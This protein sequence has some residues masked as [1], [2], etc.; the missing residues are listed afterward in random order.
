M[1][2]GDKVKMTSSGFHFYHN[3]PQRFDSFRIGD[4]LKETHCHN[5]L[6]ETLALLG[7]GEVVDTNDEY[8]KVKFKYKNAGMYFY[9]TAWYDVDDIR[10]LSLWEKL[11]SLL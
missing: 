11:C 4:S 5:M 1:K 10:K 9:A 2:I 6:C 3:I 7:T 8:Y